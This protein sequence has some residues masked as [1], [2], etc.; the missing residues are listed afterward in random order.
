MRPVHRHNG[1]TLRLF[2]HVIFLEKDIMC[3]MAEL[4]TA[5]D[6]YAKVTSEGREF[7]PHWGSPFLLRES[8]LCGLPS[9][10]ENLNIFPC[11]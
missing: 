1:P 9:S 5:S 2:I 7:E 3:P 11:Y 4:V 6:C 8:L 10:M